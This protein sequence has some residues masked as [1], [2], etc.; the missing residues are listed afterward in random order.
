MIT[1]KEY[2][3]LEGVTAQVLS[4]NWLHER[5]EALSQCKEFKNA[6]LHIVDTPFFYHEDGSIGSV[7]S[8]A[9]QDGN[10]FK[11]N[12]WLYTIEFAPTMYDP[13]TF[14]P[15]RRIVLRG[16]M[17]SD[18]GKTYVTEKSIYETWTDKWSFKL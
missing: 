8:I 16:I 14:E 9:H 2:L 11:D 6:T 7:K 5:K 10:S 4:G 1:L 17:N 13:H 18:K 15:N 12:C 3:Q